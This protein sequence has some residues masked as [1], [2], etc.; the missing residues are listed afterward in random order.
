MASKRQDQIRLTLIEILNKYDKLF[1]NIE[2]VINVL[3]AN[4]MNDNLFKENIHA[5][6]CAL[7]WQNQLANIVCFYCEL[8]N[9]VLSISCTENVWN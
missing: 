2:F 3:K 1:V 5:I 7:S 4:R 8:N 6:W 9:F